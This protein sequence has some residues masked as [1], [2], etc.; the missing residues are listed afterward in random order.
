MTEHPSHP[1]FA[2]VYDPALTLIERPIL[3][4]H[5]RW[6]VDALEGRVL[7]L[8]AGTGAMFP[9]LAMDAESADS[10]DLHAIEPD[11]H[12]RRRARR[13]ARR[14]DLEVELVAGRAEALPYADE[15]FDAVLAAMVFCTIADVDAALAEVA[16]VLRPNGELRVLEHVADVGWRRRV[17]ETLAPVWKRAAGGCHLH[18]ETGRVLAEHDAFEPETLER[19]A[20]GITPVRPF[21][22]GT[23]RR[24][25]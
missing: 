20:V 18:R 1:L 14:L 9:P 21:V 13:R 8:G 5:R 15:S 22:R 12:M 17:Q 2:A 24:R 23:L 16:R 25:A 3:H 19:G 11:P 6:L 4:P 10:I 7:D